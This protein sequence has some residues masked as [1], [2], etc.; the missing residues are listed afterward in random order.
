M[1]ETNFIEEDKLNKIIDIIN[2]VKAGT[3]CE[4]SAKDI[5]KQIYDLVNNQP[6]KQGRWIPKPAMT[7]MPF[8]K[9]YFCSE[10]GTD[11]YADN[12]CSVC[13][14]KNN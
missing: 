11:N 14:S 5:A 2:Q 10:C 8:G 13:G 6:Q 4:K 1:V 3:L 12:Y 9:N 7:R